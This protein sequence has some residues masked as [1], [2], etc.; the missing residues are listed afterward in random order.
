MGEE[1]CAEC[2]K[3]R[4]DTITQAITRRHPFALAGFPPLFKVGVGGNRARNAETARMDQEPERR[5]V[6][7]GFILENMA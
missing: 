5:E 2:Q 4:F 3:C 7:K 1:T 6:R